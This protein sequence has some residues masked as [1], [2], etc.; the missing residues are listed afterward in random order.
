MLALRANQMSADIVR[1]EHIFEA[2]AYNTM[3][4]IL[5]AILI[6]Y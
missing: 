5:E 3:R 2:T 4:T 6:G 1:P